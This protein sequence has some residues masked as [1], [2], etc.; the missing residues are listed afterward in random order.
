MFIF[1]LGL[2]F[3]ITLLSHQSYMHRFMVIAILWCTTLF[4][5][6]QTREEIENEEKS[7]LLQNK[8]C[9]Q[10]SYVHVLMIVLNYCAMPSMYYIARDTKIDGIKL[11]N[12]SMGYILCQWIQLLH[13][14]KMDGF[15]INIRSGVCRASRKDPI[16]TSLHVF[17][18]KT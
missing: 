15:S 7:M 3:I 2:P 8:C 5:K 17:F 12:D 18:F 1:Y 13:T 10:T 6:T 11:S 9:Q 14:C 16:I 4:R